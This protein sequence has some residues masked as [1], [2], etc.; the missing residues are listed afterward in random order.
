[1]DCSRGMT[2]SALS[3]SMELLQHPTQTNT[4]L[5]HSCKMVRES[6]PISRTKRA[7][8]TAKL[9]STLIKYRMTIEIIEARKDGAQKELQA[10]ATELQSIQQRAEELGVQ[11][12]NLKVQIATYN[13]LLSD[14]TSEKETEVRETME[15]LVSE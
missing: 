15:S 12:H 2:R 10:R 1:M 13:D 9:E 6:S 7:T 14:N 3:E 8:P 11:I 5:S 4:L